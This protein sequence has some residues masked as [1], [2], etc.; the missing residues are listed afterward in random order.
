MMRVPRPAG[1]EDG[2]GAGDPI[3]VG[4][5]GEQGFLR[6]F[7]LGVAIAGQRLWIG[8]CGLGDSGGVG[9][10]GD[11]GAEQDKARVGAVRRKAV[12]RFW[13]AC[14]VSRCQMAG[15]D[16]SAAA[17]W[18]TA[19]TPVSASL[20]VAVGWARSVRKVLT[21]LGKSSG[22]RMRART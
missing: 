6:Q 13:V 5:P 4:Q 16:E 14:T 21:S 7:G 10:I 22:E 12:S 9:V 2:A 3:G 8:R 15:S 18:I 17:Q 20:S 11:D 19:S 1:A